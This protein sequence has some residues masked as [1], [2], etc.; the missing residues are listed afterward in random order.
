M[1]EIT[2]EERQSILNDYKYYKSENI[3]YW[4]MKIVR[5]LDY[6][7]PLLKEIELKKMDLKIVSK[8]LAKEVFEITEL[9]KKLELYKN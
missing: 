7:N 1:Q 9:K 4:Y 3:L 5:R 8:E 6:L 2:K